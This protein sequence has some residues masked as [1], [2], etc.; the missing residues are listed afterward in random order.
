ML[1]YSATNNKIR[2]N[3]EKQKEKRED[4]KIDAAGSA[5]SLLVGKRIS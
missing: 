1:I 2:G 3:E 5:R 4:G